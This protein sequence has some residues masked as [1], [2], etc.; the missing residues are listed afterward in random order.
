MLTYSLSTEVIKQLLRYLVLLYDG[1]ENLI[2]VVF[3]VFAV[4]SFIGYYMFRAQ[5]SIRK[6]LQYLQFSTILSV[7]FA[8][9]YQIGLERLSSAWSGTLK[10]IITLTICTCQVY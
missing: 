6:L 7:V 10:A 5:L 1:M 9:A 2:I 3:A 4:E 8:L